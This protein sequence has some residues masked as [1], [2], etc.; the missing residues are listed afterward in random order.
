VG[1]VNAVAG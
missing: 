1:E